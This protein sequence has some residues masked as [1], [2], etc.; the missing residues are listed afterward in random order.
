MPIAR[1]CLGW[2]LMPK[3]PSEMLR[4]APLEELLP[5]IEV[6]PLQLVQVRALLINLVRRVM[7][8]ERKSGDANAGYDAVS[9]G[10]KEGG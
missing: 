9:A 7:E 10:R 3:A 8:L 4:D 1:L 2:L 6:Q 5:V